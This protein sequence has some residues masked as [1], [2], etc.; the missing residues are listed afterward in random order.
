MVYDIT[1][2]VKIV[3]HIVAVH[4]ISGNATMSS[5]SSVLTGSTGRVQRLRNATLP[6]QG[7]N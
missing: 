4:F 2:P 7:L 3:K 1:A 6:R 5:C